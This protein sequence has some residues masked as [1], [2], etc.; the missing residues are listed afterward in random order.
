MPDPF[1]N[2]AP[3]LPGRGLSIGYQIDFT[4]PAGTHQIQVVVRDLHGAGGSHHL[5]RLRIVPAGQPDFS[6]G[7]RT[8]KLDVPENGS[9][10]A[11]LQIQ[12]SSYSGPIRLSVAGDE[13]IS[14]WP[15]QLPAEGGNRKVF[16]TL[17]R[18]GGESAS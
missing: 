5:Y 3:I 11:Q 16:V 15:Q 1:L 12:R 4:V 18:S 6:L 17:T 13:S 7:L 14:I 10:V 9:A 8:S 2:H